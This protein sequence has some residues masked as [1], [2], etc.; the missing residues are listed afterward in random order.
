MH[1]RNL[2]WFAP[3]LL[4][5]LA[6]RPSGVD[7]DLSVAAFE[8]GPD[9]ALL[10]THVVPAA[11]MSAV[12]LLAEISTDASFE[13]GVRR[14]GAVA[15]SAHDF[16]V[17]ATVGHLEPSTRYHYR[18]RS[19]GPASRTS[20]VGTFVTA[21]LPDEVAPLRFVIS[22]D[23]NLGYTRPRN[24]D[25][26]VLSAAAEEDADVFVYF[27]DTI[28]ADSGVLPGG[29]HAVTLAE[30]RAVHRMTRA[31]PHLQ[32]LLSSTGTYTGWDD[33]EVRND[34]AG[35]TIEPERFAAGAQAFFEYLPL[36]R[37]VLGRDFRTHRTVRWGRDVEF[38]LVDGRQF[39]S[40]EQF[41]NETLPDGP[42]GPDTL[43]APFSLDD[44]IAAVLLPP[45]LFEAAA[46]LLLP[47]DPEC[48]EQRLAD[49]DRTLLGR[50]Q[51]EELKRNLL[52]SNATFKIIV[53]NTPISTL[54]FS[55]YDRWEGYLAERQELLDFI[56]EHLDPRRT[57]VLTTD[58]HT[59]LALQRD[60]LTE[61]IV[62]PIGQ[63]TFGSAVLGLLP[64]DLAPQG[65][66][67]LT[68]LQAILDRANGTG[69][70]KGSEPDAF[71]YAVVDVFR[72]DTD[73]PRLRLTV[74]GDTS[75]AEG[76]NDPA[77]VRDLF[78]VEMP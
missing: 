61:V 63:S 34:Y 42:S 43:F 76:A 2:R 9:R 31:D 29:A 20:P 40:A 6:A 52:A 28:Y 78:T 36:R 18:F 69:S 73:E 8:I 57:L 51:L 10:W 48:I 50:E 13:R 74:R 15:R 39:R 56:A 37:R 75:Y 23:S 62:G 41:C 44:E 53:N 27:G 64:P 68:F 70:V 24:L 38:F 19:V 54:L 67:V 17:R 21:P 46:G 71:S 25:F 14:T 49:P 3:L 59:N 58:F 60:E 45:S 30:Y 47:N 55:P 72:D 1:S 4:L 11:P 35:E 65:P 32:R 7:F 12:P 22:G 66:L 5:L 33:H 16:T 26:Y 77:R